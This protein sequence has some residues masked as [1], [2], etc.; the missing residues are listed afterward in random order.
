MLTSIGQISFSCVNQDFV[1]LS[2]NNLLKNKAW[3]RSS[4]C[5]LILLFKIDKSMRTSILKIWNA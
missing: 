4:V 2:A 5:S 1:F 3:L